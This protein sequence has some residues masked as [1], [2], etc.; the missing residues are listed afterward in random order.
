VHLG[1]PAPLFRSPFEL[2]TPPTRNFD[3]LPDGRFVMLGRADDEV[4]IP[5]ICVIS[6]L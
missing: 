2:R 4:E 5:E 3:L 6:N 1:L